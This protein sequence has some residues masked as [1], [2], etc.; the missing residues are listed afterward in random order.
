M[1]ARSP[2]ST[3]GEKEE[4]QTKKRVFIKQ[5]PPAASLDTQ[6]IMG[7]DERNIATSAY[8]LYEQRGREGGHDLDDGLE[9]E[10][11]LVSWEQDRGG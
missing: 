6:A 2:Q 10:Q 5:P 3:L 8:A 1:Q 11:R 7:K 4:P 9:A